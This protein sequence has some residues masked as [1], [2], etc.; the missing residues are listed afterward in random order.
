MEG[1]GALVQWLWEETPVLKVVGSNPSKAG[2]GQF[3]KWKE[4]VPGGTVPIFFDSVD[5]SLN[6][7]GSAGK[8]N[9]SKMVH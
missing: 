9:I 8:R 3:K 6:P 2:D 5:E 1:A 7:V 4:K